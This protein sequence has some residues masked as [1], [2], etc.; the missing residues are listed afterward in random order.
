MT[1]AGKVAPVWDPLTDERAA[2]A[3]WEG[4][5]DGMDWR[6]QMKEWGYAVIPMSWRDN[7]VADERMA[8]LVEERWQPA[9]R[10][11]TPSR[12][13][14]KTTPTTRGYLR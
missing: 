10:G 9:Y 4:S 2:Q 14:D 6:D 3:W 11:S 1:V 7:N 12:L 13:W 5:G 8:M